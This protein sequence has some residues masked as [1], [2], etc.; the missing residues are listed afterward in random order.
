[1]IT[2]SIFMLRL[3]EY[4]NVYCV[5]LWN[6]LLGRRK[7]TLTFTCNDLLQQNSPR[8]TFVKEE[9]TA[10]LFDVETPLACLSFAIDCQTFDGTGNK[11][12]LSPLMKLSDNW[13][14]EDQRRNRYYINVCRPINPVNST[15]CP[16]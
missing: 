11:Y 14:V 2:A 13:V 8:I 12:D 16:G 7:V 10:L 9:G 1:M 4:V 15:A 6:L 5:I 3:S